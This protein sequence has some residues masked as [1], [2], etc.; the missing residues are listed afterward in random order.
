MFLFHRS[1]ATTYQ[2][3]RIKHKIVTWLEWKC[4]PGYS[5]QDCQLRGEWNCKFLKLFT[6]AKENNAIWVVSK[7]SW[8]KTI[9]VFPG[10]LKAE[11]KAQQP[12]GFWL[13]PAHIL[14]GKLSRMSFPLFHT[15]KKI[16]IFSLLSFYWSMGFAF[17]MSLLLTFQSQNVAVLGMRNSSSLLNICF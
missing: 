8:W 17:T 3:Y 4:C 2:A 6:S 11:R 5:G 1:Q 12:L 14:L 15:K 16:K 13:F 7:W 9:A 10:N